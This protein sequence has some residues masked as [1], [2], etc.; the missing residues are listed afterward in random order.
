MRLSIPGRIGTGGGEVELAHLNGVDEEIQRRREQDRLVPIGP[1]SL[2]LVVGLLNHL[3]AQVVVGKLG[4]HVAA[5]VQDL[6]DL[7][8]AQVDEGGG[9]S[10]RVSDGLESIGTD[11]VTVGIVVEGG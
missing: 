7:P 8:R 11:R 9:L 4:H 2:R 3:S 1:L 6:R 5:S 10:G